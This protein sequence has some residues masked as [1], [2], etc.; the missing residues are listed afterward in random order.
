MGTSRNRVLAA[1]IGIVAA[2][3]VLVG[4]SDD[5]GTTPA[6]S[7]SP[8][9]SGGGTSQVSTGGNTEVKVEGQ[10]LQQYLGGKTL[11]QYLEWEL[12]FTDSIRLEDSLARAARSIAKADLIGYVDYRYY[13]RKEVLNRPELE[14]KLLE[15]F[16]EQWAPGRRTSREPSRKL[17]S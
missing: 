11:E 6:A 17:D 13:L 3:A 8:A 4:C 10:A 12:D 2:A 5:K 14:E 9:A 16:M 15:T 1:G 7:S